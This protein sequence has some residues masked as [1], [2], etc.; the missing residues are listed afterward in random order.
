[1]RFFIF[2]ALFLSVVFLS[3]NLGAGESEEQ[4]TREEWEKRRPE[5]ISKWIRLLGTHASYR[6]KADPV[7]EVRFEILEEETVESI[8]RIL[9]RYTTEPGQKVEAYLLIPQSVEKTK[10]PGVVVFHTTSPH[11]HRQ[12]AGI[13]GE[14]E[15]AFGWN[16]AKKGFITLSPKNFIWPESGNFDRKLAEDYLKRNPNSKGISRMLL[17]AQ[18]AVDLLYG[19]EEVDRERIFCIGHSLGAKETLYLAAFDERIRGAISSE[20]GIGIEHSNW[21]APWYL[22]ASA[23]EEDFP[24]NH[25]ELL[26]LVAPRP[27]LLI[28]GGRENGGSDGIESEDYIRSARKIYELYDRGEKI[29]FF[30]HKKGHSLPVEAEEK[31]LRWV[32]ERL[33][34]SENSPEA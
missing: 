33:A 32:E 31:I 7:P 15:K 28:G 24:G 34:E 2:A 27:F 22:G 21:E 17:D 16:F 26:A 29:E 14:K 12:P 11:A 13:S 6:S 5:I 25:R 3:I 4:R 10:R 18:C 30:L 23:K 9:I 19:L 8:R 1:M 20:G